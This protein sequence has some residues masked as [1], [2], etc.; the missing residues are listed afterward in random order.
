MAIIPLPVSHQ[1]PCTYSH[2][3]LHPPSYPSFMPPCVSLLFNT[4]IPPTFSPCIATF[5]T[6]LFPSWHGHAR[7]HWTHSMHTTCM[8][9]LI[10]PPLDSLPLLNSLTT[11]SPPIYLSS[12]CPFFSPYSLFTIPMN[13]A[14]FSLFTP[15]FHFLTPTSSPMIPILLSMQISHH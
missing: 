14:T 12:L 3:S 8:Y 2:I 10:P 6:H 11:Y 1:P 13:V 7:P 15:R 4:T 9:V 5:H